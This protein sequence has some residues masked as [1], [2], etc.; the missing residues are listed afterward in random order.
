MKSGFLVDMASARLSK[1]RQLLGVAVRRREGESHTGIRGSSQLFW[2]TSSP[3]Q[4]REV[5][6]DFSS[7][8]FMTNQYKAATELQS[9]IVPTDFRI[10]YMNR[11]SAAAGVG[12]EG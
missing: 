5:P 9:C 1:K 3:T 8:F 11:P 7:S 10:L 2:L 6:L 12:A 4:E